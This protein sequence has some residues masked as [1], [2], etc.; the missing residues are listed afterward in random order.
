MI[1]GGGPGWPPPE[2]PPWAWHAVFAVAV[3]TLAAGLALTWTG[4]LLSARLLSLARPS[5]L[6]AR[7]LVGYYLLERGRP[8]DALAHFR[9]VVARRPDYGEA[10]HWEGLA[11]A[12]SGDH[13]G[14]ASALEVA[15][16]IQR[17]VLE[18]LE[19]ASRDPEA[20]PASRLLERLEAS[21]RRTV[22]TLSALGVAAWR[23]GRVG[24]ALE[25]LEGA[26]GL[27][28]GSARAHNDLAWVLVTERPREP[29]PLGRALLH[30]ERAVALDPS[31]AAC[32]GTLGAVRLRQGLPAEAAG[33][34]ERALQA[35][36]ATGGR[37]PR[38][39]ATDLC[40]LAM[41][42]AALGQE[43]PAREA[44]DAALRAGPEARWRLEA[45]EAVRG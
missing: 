17:P 34:L 7:L 42:R 27:E 40:L 12:Q 9:W 16:R 30:A 38:S 23:A 22:D 4:R 29:E 45:E 32:L 37:A 36:G 11:L 14:A 43:G 33:L 35:R 19:A 21:R 10:H 39:A 5:D 18:R 44:L 3:A 26:V 41:A 1:L 13:A 28:P 6:E 25:A 31:S 20:S 2:V 8:R 24:Q 15:A